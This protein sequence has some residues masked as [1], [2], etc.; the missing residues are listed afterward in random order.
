MSRERITTKRAIWTTKGYTDAGG[1][2]HPPYAYVQVA[3]GQ[4]LKMWGDKAR[5]KVMRELPEAFE[6]FNPQIEVVDI[7]ESG[8]RDVEII[9]RKREGEKHFAPMR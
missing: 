8:G 5:K 6:A 1:K 9:G 3:R 4:V 7:V 2:F